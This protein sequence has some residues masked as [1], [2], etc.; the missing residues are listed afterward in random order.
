MRAVRSRTAG[1]PET[2]AV[3]ELPDPVPAAGEVLI[4]VAAAGLNR[5]DSLQRRGRA[6]LPPG[7]SDIFGMEVSGTVAEPGPGTGDFRRGEEVVALLDSGGYATR[8]AVPAAQVLPVP[9]G[10]GVIDA[11]GLPEA[12]ATLVSNLCMAARFR[13]GETVLIHGATGGIGTFG[14]QL[15]KAL[16]GRAAVTASSPAK[17]DAA[18]KLGADIL[19]NY[20]AEDFAQVMAEAGGADIVLD[21]VAGPY[22]NR[23]LQALAPCGRIVTIGMQGGSQGH[24]NFA[25]L[26]K[27]KASVTGTLLRDRPAEQKAGIMAAT[28]RL[29]WPLL[30]SGDITV[31]TDRVFPLSQ[32]ARAHEYFDSKDHVG[33]V[34]LDCRR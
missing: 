4:D 30:E 2:L 9:R 28:R 1:G 21:T 22:L 7:A 14:I 17:L 29:V 24:L 31:T 26:M 32:V 27:K 23:N 19:I 18:A 10:I 5:A 16:G 25:M 3:E 6:N 34:L 11:A 8:V 33:K 15:V 12:A 20:T 13:A